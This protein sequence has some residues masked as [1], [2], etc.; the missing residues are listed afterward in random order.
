[1][2]SNENACVH[3]CN[4]ISNIWNKQM[5]EFK[6]IL[7]N[8]PSCII[9]I[10]SLT[11]ILC[12]LLY[13]LASQTTNVLCDECLGWWMSEVV[14]VW[15]GECL[16]WWTSGVVNVWGGERLILHWGWWTSGV[17]NVW[18][19]ERLRWWTSEV[20]NVWGG[21]R[22][23]LHRG[24]WTSEV[25]NVWVVNVLQS[26]GKTGHQSAITHLS[27]QTQMLILLLPITDQKWKIAQNEMCTFADMLVTAYKI[28]VYIAAFSTSLIS[29]LQRNV[30]TSS[31]N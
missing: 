13:V 14:N 26:V 20:V 21:E 27:E 4:L 1:M 30:V 24:W 5:K 18:G 11:C 16:R 6:N 8:S 19:G 17:V 3:H 25:V 7:V 2:E 31:M 28:N 22:L 10:C 15:G 12:S 9:L 23:I 29:K